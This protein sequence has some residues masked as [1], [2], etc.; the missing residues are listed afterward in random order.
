M[1][2]EDIIS[3]STNASRIDTASFQKIS[4]EIEV[5]MSFFRKV[6]SRKVIYSGMIG[7]FGP[8]GTT[9]LPAVTEEYPRLIYSC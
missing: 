3:S 7:G 5:K 1:D 6:K 8:A 4:K 9:P 2:K